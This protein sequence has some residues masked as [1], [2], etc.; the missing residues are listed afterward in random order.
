MAEN[1]KSC[2]V[3]VSVTDIELST[4]DPTQLDSIGR[5]AQRLMLRVQE[6]TYF[7]EGSL[8]K[9][10]VDDK[11]LLIVLAFGLAPLLHSDDEVRA[12]RA[13]LDI[14]S[15][16]QLIDPQCHAR[17]G[18]TTGDTFCGIVGHPTLR[19]EFTVMGPVVN[20]CARLMMQAQPNGVMVCEA[21]YRRTYEAFAY[22][23]PISMHLKGIG[24]CCGYIPALHEEG[25][26]LQSVYKT[27]SV[28]PHGYDSILEQVHWGRLNEV[29][30]LQALLFRT[31][32][33][34]GIHT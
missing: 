14:V 8:N 27:L 28:R 26:C 18:V 23:D 6:I 29:F 11:G 21:T 19:H 5:L 30:L 13:A 1:W 17:A 4:E 3:F 9:V 2:I 15:N 16:I 34:G 20:L 10:M 33:N 12:V 25:L 22:G 32:C 24:T 31:A 7:W